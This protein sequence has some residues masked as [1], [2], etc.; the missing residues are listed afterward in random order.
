MKGLPLMLFRLIILT[1]FFFVSF[2]T[3]S[4]ETAPS[5][6][7]TTYTASNSLDDSL[8]KDQP[9]DPDTAS[10]SLDQIN[11]PQLLKEGDT[12]ALQQLISNIN[13]LKIK[14]KHCIDDSSDALEKLDKLTPP[15]TTTST[16]T[17]PPPTEISPA[18]QQ[19]IEQ[20]QQTLKDEAAK[21]RLFIIRAN[22][23]TADLSQELRKLLEGELFY[24]ETN[25]L[26]DFIA[27]GSSLLTLKQTFNIQDFLTASG[28][29]F[30][31][32]TKV[33]IL[34]IMPIFALTIGAWLKYF[35][36]QYIGEQPETRYAYQL[37]QAFFS[38]LSRYIVLLLPIGMFS[39]CMTIFNHQAE[40]YT[41][42]TL[43]S[44][45]LLLYVIFLALIRFFFY[46]PKPA[47]TALS[48]IP[49][50]LAKSLFVRANIFA[51][52]CLIT[53]L[54]Y[55][56]FHVQVIPEPLY[57]VLKTIAITLISISLI[58]V[59]W[60][61]QK[62]PKLLNT[63]RVLRFFINILLLIALTG[64]LTAESLGYHQLSLYLLK[65][66]VITATAAYVTLLLEKLVKIGANG[67]DAYYSQGKLRKY[68]GLGA[69]QR[70]VE[71]SCLRII[72]SFL[73]W[74]G[75]FLFL[76]RTWGL[77][78]TIFERI[79]TALI[80]GFQIG[81]FDIIP[82]RIIIAT[83]IFIFLSILTRFLRTYFVRNTH[84]HLSLGNRESLGTII[85]YLGFSLSVLIGLLVAGINLS[86][87]L[88]IAGALSVGIGFGLQNIAK[89]FISG[90]ILLIE[91]PIKL[92]DRIVV[93]DKEGHVRHIG[94]RATHIITTQ[95]V[96]MI[97][98]NSEI[99]SNNL[100]NYM[101]YDADYYLIVSVN[102]AYGNNVELVKNTLLAIAQEHPQVVKDRVG[103]E[104]I[105]FFSEFGEGA[106][107]F[108]LWCLIKDANF[109][110]NI[111]SSLN[112]QVEQRFR[113]YGIKLAFPQSDVNIQNWPKTPS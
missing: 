18:D 99:I 35:F 73:I 84:Q 48:N 19:Y 3:Y 49:H 44:Y 87:I 94:I 75:F 112:F 62:L 98:P 53:S 74:A 104:P 25:A 36:A 70:L 101:L 107:K 90:I 55:L 32:A 42:L 2:P 68:L 57:N 28:I 92:G 85:K 102:V 110:G 8:T 96:D 81:S 6:D 93:G 50:S 69:K 56:F 5:G 61:V 109:K 71:L 66:I 64:L 106:L 86:N 97:V 72:L 88:I 78:K 33:I 46:P 95:C 13:K 59:I 9:F 41:Y 89:D 80:D 7:L 51:D 30:L 10:K 79:V 22:E 65:N 24:A 4:A 105:V 27:S 37:R 20:K 60:L 52:I 77:G 103:Y 34:I 82:S 100:T 54:G 14:A 113:E 29:K 76:L 1:C 67:S 111:R 108:N 39:I 26:Q 23:V 63:F 40:Q 58:S 31:D 15:S 11:I 12:S 17:P 83:L 43:S 16:D 38:V 45:S 47:V 91:R 21:C